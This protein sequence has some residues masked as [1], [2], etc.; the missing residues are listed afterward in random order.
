[1]KNERSRLHFPIAAAAG[2]LLMANAG[3][4]RADIILG[5][6]G[7]TNSLTGVVTY[8]YSNGAFSGSGVYLGSGT[9]PVGGPSGAAIA[10]V[11]QLGANDYLYSYWLAIASSQVT[12]ANEATPA[13]FITLLD[14]PGYMAGTA[15]T[16]SAAVAAGGARETESLLATGTCSPPNPGGISPGSPACAPAAFAGYVAANDNPNLMDITWIAETAASGVTDAGFAYQSTFGPDV[17][18]LCGV[19][20][21]QANA[22]SDGGLDQQIGETAI[23]DPPASAPEPASMFLMGGALCG[24]GLVGR[25]RR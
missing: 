24:L 7:S 8:C 4:S 16:D 13:S 22:A 20:L 2:I 1:M 25:K 3:V 17:C 19:F 18:A 5:L 14:I 11:Q 10:G 23:P 12:R 15:A 6:C 21:D 9:A